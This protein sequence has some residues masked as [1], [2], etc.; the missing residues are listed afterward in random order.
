MLLMLVGL[1]QRYHAALARESGAIHEVVLSLLKVL[2]T[3]GAD[4]RPIP[5]RKP[6]FAEDA[7]TV[8]T[9][10]IASTIHNYLAVAA[11]HGLNTVLRFRITVAGQSVDTRCPTDRKETPLCI[12][13]RHGTAATVKLLLELGADVSLRCNEGRGKARNALEI[14]SAAA[15]AYHPRSTYNVGSKEPG[16]HEYAECKRILF[17]PTMGYPLPLPCA[18]C[19][20]RTL[21]SEGAHF[22]THTVPEQEL[23]VEMWKPGV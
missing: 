11:L 2:H 13:A 3:A 6:D 15:S 9:E 23:L 7:T 20:S 8:P 16:F 4:F 5:F 18:T 21:V 22:S 17:E 10:E 12:A 14:V 19:L 1:Q